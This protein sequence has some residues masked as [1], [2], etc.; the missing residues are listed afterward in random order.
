MSFVIIERKK[1]NSFEFKTRLLVTQFIAGCGTDSTKQ[2]REFVAEL[3]PMLPEFV[4]LVD[5]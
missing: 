1:E 4:A 3:E 2:N 5:T